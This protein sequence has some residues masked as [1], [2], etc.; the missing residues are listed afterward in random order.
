[1]AQT[2]ILDYQRYLNTLQTLNDLGQTFPSNQQ[3]YTFTVAG[4]GTA[5]WPATISW[6]TLILDKVSFS[7]KETGYIPNVDASQIVGYF[8][9]S[10]ATQYSTGVISIPANMYTGPILP[11]GDYHVPLTVVHIEWFD[12]ITT[13]AQQIGFIQNWEPGVEIGDPTLDTDYHPVYGLPST[14]TLSGTS[15]IAF[16]DTLVLTATTDM[17]VDLG[18]NTMV[19]FYRIDGENNILLGTRYFSGKQASISIATEP[20]FPIASYQFYAK[21]AAKNPYTSAISNTLTV[22]VVEAVPLLIDS[23][24][25]VPS[26]TYYYPGDSV[27]YSL[28]VYPDPSFPPSG[29]AVAN[30]LT[31]NT[32]NGWGNRNEYFVEN[33]NFNNGLNQATFTI[34]NAMI[35]LTLSD[36][37]TNYVINSSSTTTSSYSTNLFVYNTQSVQTNWQ[38]TKNGRYAEGVYTATILVGT[39]TNKTTVGESFIMT[40][41]QSTPESLF[42]ER[43]EITVNTPQTQYYNN[44][45]LYARNGGTTILLYS[46]NARGSASFTTSTVGLLSTGTWELYATYPGDV[47]SSVY[48]ANLPA[49]ST[50]IYHYI[51]VGNLKG[52]M[53][54]TGWRTSTNDYLN[55]YASATKDLVRDVTFKNGTTVL[56]TSTFVRRVT[57]FNTQ[58]ATIELPLNSVNLNATTSTTIHAVWTGT[59]DLPTIYGKFDAVDVYLTNPPIGYTISANLVSEAINSTTYITSNI[60]STNPVQLR[61]D[62]ITDYYQ[63]PVPLNTGT[64]VFSSSGGG[65]L[66]LSSANGKAV[67]TASSIDSTLAISNRPFKIINNQAISNEVYSDEV[68]LIP[69]STVT[70]HVYGEIFTST[71][72]ISGAGVG[73]TTA[74][75]TNT[76]SLVAEVFDYRVR[77]KAYDYPITAD[78]HWSTATSTSTVYWDVTKGYEQW[79]TSPP[80]GRWGT[81][82]RKFNT[83]SLT[84]SSFPQTSVNVQKTIL[85]DEVY[86]NANIRSENQAPSVHKFGESGPNLKPADDG[87]KPGWGYLSNTNI[88]VGTTASDYLTDGIV[89]LKGDIKVALPFPVIGTSEYSGGIK[90][91]GTSSTIDLCFMYDLSVRSDE[92]PYSGGNSLI[93]WLAPGTPAEYAYPNG[94]VTPA[95]DNK[96]F[97]P[98]PDEAKMNAGMSAQ[99]MAFNYYTISHSQL[100]PNILTF[101]FDTTNL[102]NID[103]NSEYGLPTPDSYYRSYY[104]AYDLNNPPIPDYGEIRQ[105]VPLPPATPTSFVHFTYKKRDKTYPTLRYNENLNLPGFPGGGQRPFQIGVYL[106]I[107]YYGFTNNG[108][109]VGGNF[110]PGTSTIPALPE[111]SRILVSSKLYFDRRD[112]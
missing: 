12:G 40:L 2:G 10:T 89:V 112:P 47:G 23:S 6:E 110:I 66:W 63:Y 13:Y 91:Y 30:T 61:A 14:L 87:P 27:Q 107:N 64:F 78:G 36:T 79:P 20:D 108:L 72:N 41:T 62:I 56:G 105:P 86:W 100:T 57:G 73:F 18:S 16:G 19:R 43:F 106:V 5:T 71:V 80:T 8:D 51:V 67:S 38:F 104:T 54:L 7:S 109:A 96:L 42:D 55:L 9:G 76:V 53:I 45:S 81:P 69:L 75:N 4:G 68:Y 98:F 90:I 95:P 83:S 74:Y 15:V 29:I 34:T 49:T 48:N 65:G 70:S 32:I 84:I 60:Y 22:E 25:F 17:A 93:D 50:S 26:K 1:M 11:G 102:R 52:A 46:H 101:N 97:L 59:Q 99:S 37:S 77:G 3:T 28:Q 92:A 58:T 33:D 39:T 88:Q 21:S 31:V 94:K 35:D 24:T 44:I 111:K 85:D 82:I 103:G